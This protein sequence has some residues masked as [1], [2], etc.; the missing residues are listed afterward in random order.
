MKSDFGP[1]AEAAK[2]YPMM[3][4][5]KDMLS[6]NNVGIPSTVW[7]KVA[8]PGAQSIYEFKFCLYSSSQKALTMAHLRRAHLGLVVMCKFCDKTYYKGGDWLAHMQVDH[9][10]M[11]VKNWTGLPAPYVTL[12]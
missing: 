1:K 2:F 6:C 4:A 10:D 8:N 3:V 11:K 5:S 9:K 12:K 7:H